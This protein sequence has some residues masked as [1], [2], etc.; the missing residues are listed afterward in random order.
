MNFKPT[1]GKIIASILI[2]V[3]SWVPL[4]F[5][6]ESFI[7]KIVDLTKIFSTTNIIIF[8]IE[9]I[10][11][12][13]LFSLFQRSNKKMVIM[14]EEDLRKMMQNNQAPPKV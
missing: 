11:L 3:L 2:G 8:I 12:Y 14:R 13:L 5:I 1:I 6:K 9:I 7:L 4:F 10:I